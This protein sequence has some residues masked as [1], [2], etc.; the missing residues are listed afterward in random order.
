MKTE[1]QSNL[2]VGFNAVPFDR[3]NVTFHTNAGEPILQIRSDG[4]FW[5][6]GKMV[7]LD[8]GEGRKVYEAFC[9][10]LKATGTL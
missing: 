3:H 8:D 10:W 1:T 5:V 2:A 6:R 9:E 7:E 4:T